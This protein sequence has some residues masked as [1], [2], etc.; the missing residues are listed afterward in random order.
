[1]IAVIVAVVVVAVVVDVAVVVAVAAP[2]PA[3]YASSP[4]DQATRPSALFSPCSLRGRVSVAGFLL[5]DGLVHALTSFSFL[6]L[7]VVL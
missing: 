6:G 4:A 3:A 2:K 1:M 5:S 7:A